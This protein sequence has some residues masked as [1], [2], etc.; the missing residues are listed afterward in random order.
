M[1]AYSFFG[2]NRTIL[3]SRLKERLKKANMDEIS[4]YY[5]LIRRDGEESRSCSMC[6]NEPYTF[7]QEHIS[8]RNSRILCSAHLIKYKQEKGIGS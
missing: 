1:K 5:A 2:S 8:V 6:N 3:E 4:D 7:F